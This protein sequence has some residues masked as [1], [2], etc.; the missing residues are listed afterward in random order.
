MIVSSVDRSDKGCPS[1]AGLAEPHE[2]QFM[3]L[4]LESLRDKLVQATWAAMDI[5]ESI[6]GGAMKVVV[7]RGGDTRQFISIAS[8]GHIHNAQIAILLK[9]ANSS[10]DGPDAK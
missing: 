2:R 7:V 6:A 4:E 3:I 1:G 5:E 8:T 10:V 9:T